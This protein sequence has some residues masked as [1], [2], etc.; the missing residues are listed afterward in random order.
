M[1]NKGVKG[2]R[3]H[4]EGGVGLWIWEAMKGVKVHNKEVGA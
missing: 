3:G 1:S 4:N 2:L